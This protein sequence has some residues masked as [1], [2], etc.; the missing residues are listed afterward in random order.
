MGE[1]CAQVLG[2]VHGAGEDE[3]AFEG[4]EELVCERGEIDRDRRRMRPDGRFE[5]LQ[6]AGS[7]VADRGGDQVVFA[8]CG[9]LTLVDEG[10]EQATGLGGGDLV[11][12]L[13]EV[14][15]EGHE[16]LG[17]VVAVGFGEGH[18]VGEHLLVGGGVAFEQRTAELVLGREVVEERALAG[19][20]LR[21]HGVPGSAA[22]AARSPRSRSS[23]APSPVPRSTATPKRRQRLKDELMAAVRA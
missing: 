11:R 3:A 8:I 22:T 6:Q 15:H 5:L 20:R 23:R 10:D 17:G 19:R 16:L 9:E 14:A 13:L 7:P 18:E 2:V 12:R 4:G 21:E 1:L